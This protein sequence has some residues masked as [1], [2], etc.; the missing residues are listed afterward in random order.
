MPPY[1]QGGL[2]AE[3]KLVLPKRNKVNVIIYTQYFGPG[4]IRILTRHPVLLT[5]TDHLL[6]PHTDADTTEHQQSSSN[7]F[8]MCVRCH[9]G[10][11]SK[12]TAFEIPV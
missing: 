7:A 6:V 3:L 9:K 10:V 4:L 2:L 5:S 1:N 11:V 12:L 8:Y